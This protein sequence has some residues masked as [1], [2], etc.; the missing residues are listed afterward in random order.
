MYCSYN[1]IVTCISISTANDNTPYR[2]VL[3][4]INN[5]WQQQHHHDNTHVT[6]DVGDSL[7]VVFRGVGNISTIN[8]TNMINATDPRFLCET[9]FACNM[10]LRL[11]D[12]YNRGMECSL[13]TPAELSDNGRILTVILDEMDQLNI[14]IT[15]KY[16]ISTMGRFFLAQ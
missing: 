13:H 4:Y 15:G 7:T 11:S 10:E 6:I 8:A 3:V 14:T 9:N 5:T 2:D 1:W 16:H 12:V